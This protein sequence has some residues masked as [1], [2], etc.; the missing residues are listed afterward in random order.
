MF[1]IRQSRLIGAAHFLLAFILLPVIFVFGIYLSLLFLLIIIWLIILGTKLWSHRKDS[2]IQLRI[3]HFV[4]LPASVLIVLYGFFAL[5]KA[6]L[7][8]EEGGGLLGAFGFIP[9]IIGFLMTVLSFISIW[10]SYSIKSE[11]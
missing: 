8:A 11:G 6:N 9:I 10:V 7:S 5:N 2:L 4:F 3:T 1:T